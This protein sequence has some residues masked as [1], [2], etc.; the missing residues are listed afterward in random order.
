MIAL[1]TDQGIKWLMGTSVSFAGA[2]PAFRASSAFTKNKE[3]RR[4][5]FQKL[6]PSA[7]EFWRRFEAQGA[8]PTAGEH[9]LFFD[10]R[11]P[12]GQANERGDGSTGEALQRT[13]ARK[14]LK[15]RAS[16]R[17]FLN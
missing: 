7:E 10:K 13:C 14:S 3:I 1:I 2:G 16:L 5:E 6:R 4:P 11:A 12:A 17:Y 9:A 15:D 8:Q